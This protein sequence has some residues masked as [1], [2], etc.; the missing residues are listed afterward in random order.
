[1]HNLVEKGAYALE[2]CV[3]ISLA[4][5]FDAA[6]AKAQESVNASI[7]DL[8]TNVHRK[9]HCSKPQASSNLH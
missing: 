1:M 3:D 7:L 4:D 9:A 6:M 8:D 5:T 2:K